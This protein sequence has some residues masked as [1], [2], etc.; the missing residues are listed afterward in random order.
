MSSSIARRRRLLAVMLPLLLAACAAPVTQRARIDRGAEVAES[1]RQQQIAIRSF[2]DQ[3]KR[4]WRLARPLLVANADLCGD[5]V[6]ADPGLLLWFGAGINPEFRA[7]A[8]A[9]GL[10]LRAEVIAV[11]PESPA[12]RAGVRIGDEIRRVDGVDLPVDRAAPQVWQQAMVKAARQSEWS[13]DLLRDG[14]DVRLQVETQRACA[15]PAYV[16]NGNEVN[17]F[18]DGKAMFITRGMMRFAQDDQELSLVLGHE[19]AHNIMAHIDKKKT[20]AGLGLVLDL[21]AAAGGVNTRGAFSNMAASAYSQ[22]FEAEA[23]YVGVYLLERAGVDTAGAA[24][25]WRRMA[26]EH[27]ANIRNNHSASHPA[28]SRRFI[29]I[30]Q[31]V[32]EI[33][34]KR[35]SGQPLKPNM[36]TRRAGS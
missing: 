31:T 29:A 33:A 30:E 22:E 8:E 25:F 19:L 13:I 10:G 11:A 26:A 32:E 20:N 12:G 28:T 17:A 5:A 3:Q 23:D 21:L 6:A 16:V 15:Y 36:E 35:R 1:N 2:N 27:P 34:D 18:A 9:V 24:D 7:A 4:L 14:R